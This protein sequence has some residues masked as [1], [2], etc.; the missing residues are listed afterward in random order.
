MPGFKAAVQIDGQVAL[1]CNAVE[2]AKGDQNIH[3]DQLD[4]W[5]G[6]FS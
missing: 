4:K 6:G 1:N 3:F 5:M 2:A